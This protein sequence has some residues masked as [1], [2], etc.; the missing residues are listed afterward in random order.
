[1]KKKWLVLT[2]AAA[3]VTLSACSNENIATTKAGNIT[4]NELY[5]SM[6]T[7]AG[8]QALYSLL[9]QKIAVNSV[10]DK[11]AVTKQTD[12]LIATRKQTAGGDAAFKKVLLQNGYDSE[13]AFK[14]TIYANYAVLQVVK[15]H[16]TPTDE[17]LEK[18]YESWEPKVTASHILVKDEETAKKVLEELNNGGDWNALAKQYSTDKSNS[19]KGGSLGSFKP[20]AMVAEFATAVRDMKE[21][22][23]SS[24][25]V[26][27]TFGYHIIKM[28]SK[29]AKTTFDADKEKFK[30]EYID[31]QASDKTTQQNVIEELLKDAD[32]KISDVFLNEALS[33]L[34]QKPTANEQSV[35]QQG[36][37]TESK[38]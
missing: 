21:G 8:K 33:S 34:L 24:T 15:E 13:E 27:T 32:I 23:T 19:E 1:M 10:K 38:K 3:V 36:T 9:V 29:P 6:R 30:T 31:D 25:P 22:E 14:Q 37:T 11:A 28:E 26:K 7:T 5:D 18:A 16:V 35:S 4:K 17:E 2:T 12:E 20:S